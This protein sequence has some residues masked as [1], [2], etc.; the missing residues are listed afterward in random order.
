MFLS[1]NIL[2]IWLAWHFFEA[3][4]EILKGWKNFL[5]FNL[6]YFSIPLLLKTFFAP[7]RRYSWSYGWGF[8]PKRYFEVALSNL[9]SR[10]IGMVLRSVLILIG[11]IM[12]IFVILVGIIILLGWLVLPLFLI[13]GIYY[14]FRQILL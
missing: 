14:G 13:L 11:L 12:E 7:W 2:I 1:N 3:S 8:D 4:R 10:V 6:K 5:L 9:F